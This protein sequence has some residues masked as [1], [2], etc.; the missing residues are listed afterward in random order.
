MRS[1]LL[2]SAA[3]IAAATPVAA[4]AADDT[5]SPLVDVIV[6]T[7]PRSP[8]ATPT[9]EAVQPTT[10]SLPDAAAL[11]S[12]IPG[13]ARIGNGALSGQ[14]Q[15]R[16][17]FG[18]RLNLRVDGQSFGSAGPNLMDPPLH[19]APT[20]LLAALEVD[21]GVSPVRDGPGLAGGMNA[22][23]KRI[24]YAVGDTPRLG[25]DL[26]TG[27]R[28]G[29]SSYSGGGIVGA[30]TET[31]RA[32]LLGSYEKGRDTRFPG[33]KIASSR[34]ERAVY[35]LSAGA[36]TGSQEVSL[37]LRHQHTSPTGNP[38]FPMDIRY[39]DSDFARLGYTATLGEFG[40]E[41]A[42]SYADVDHAMNNFGLRPAPAAMQQRETLAKA[43]TRTAELALTAPL[44]GGRLRVGADAERVDRNVL[45][46]NPA[47]PAFA[48]TPLPDI[49]E[50]RAGAYA[51]WTGRLGPVDGELGVR[52]DHHE[53]SAGQA[54]LGALPTGG[55]VMLA[56]AFNAADRTR[57]NTTVDAVAR[58]WTEPRDGLSW[59]LTLAHKTRVPGYLERFGWLP[60]SASGGL[61]DGNVYVG[62]LNLKPEEAW[63]GEV[64]FDFAGDTAYLRPTAFIREIDNYIQGV[65]FDATPGVL[66]TVQENVAA[67]NG[68]STPLRFANVDA[69]LYGLDVAGGLKLSP[70]WR[71]DAVVSYVRGKRRDISDN[72][73]RISP[74]SL[75]TTLTYEADRWSVSGETRVV[76]DQNKVSQTN[77]EQRTG[78]YAVFAVYGDWRIH[79]GVR[80]SAGVENLLDR[81]Y[82]DHLAG[83]NRITGSDVPVGARLP[84]MGRSAFVRLS[85]VG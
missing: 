56:N 3:A 66:D 63:I 38:P 27:G 37:D 72:L 47:V 42:L 10:L 59:R 9:T 53:A 48:V 81:R 71:V 46:T 55:P 43:I 19:Y 40:V 30:A 44:A 35:G 60:T 49:A 18:E 15:Y 45:I 24:G 76:A 5:A 16:G 74:P 62:D 73:Y 21:R 33:G 1:F 84:G 32:N 85:L 51:E 23:F 29:D 22:V 31:W 25:Y 36:R 12:R 57:D 34:Y 64:G 13:G 68:D 28:T 2:A 70:H 82:S 6:V 79:E 78:G 8:A 67:M 52:A 54:I 61:A 77:S 75:T 14:A 65:P 11:M 69:R 41:A 39:F 26:T 80:V 58:F 20:T 50:R 83:Y 4:S 7:A 17:L